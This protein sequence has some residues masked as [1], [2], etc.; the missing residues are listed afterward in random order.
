MKTSYLIRLEDND[1]GQILD[2]LRA[3]EESWRKTA[4]YFRFG[5][6]ADGASVI[7][8]CNDEHEA[9]R[10]AEFYSR[11]IRDV[12]RQRDEQRGGTKETT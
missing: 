4:D 10:I 6:S 12:E 5:Y 9:A 2:G 1:L 3:R 8:E 11:I 7:E